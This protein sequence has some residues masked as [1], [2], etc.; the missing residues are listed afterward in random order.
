MANAFMLA[1]PYATIR[2]MSSYNFSSGNIHEG[3][4][5][6]ENEEIISVS[7]NDDGTC[8]HPWI[9]EHRWHPIVEMVKFRINVFGTDITKWRAFA[10]NTVA[11]C[12]EDKGFIVFSKSKFD[13]LIGKPVFVCVAPGKYCDVIAGYDE[14]G[15]CI[16][17][18][19]VDSGRYAILIKKKETNSNGVIALHIG[20]R[21][22]NI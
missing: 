20:S 22:Q 15:N 2:V 19:E 7:V 21:I 1:Y 9:C 4:P 6:D 8:E 18:I 16:N 11:F 3:P 10:S 12:R 13:C 17:V 14:N 5:M